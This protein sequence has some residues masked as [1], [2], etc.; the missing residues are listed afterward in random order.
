GA[1]IL[2]GRDFV[3]D[4]GIAPP[5]P[6]PQP[7]GA[8]PVQQPPQPR[9]PIVGILSYQFWQSRF[10]G[11]PNI[12]GKSIDLGGN[13]VD[14]V[15]ILSPEFELLFPPNM[16]VDTLPAVYTAARVNF[17]TGSRQNVA[18]RLVGRLKDGVSLAQTRAQFE[19]LSADLRK[20]FPVQESAG[21]NL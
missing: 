6:P 15:G 14:I 21:T 7:A 8:P 1:R 11:N 10:G 13:K 17:E 16:R 5:P 2:L 4:D 18:W 3:E 12:V 9:L 19:R 20:Q